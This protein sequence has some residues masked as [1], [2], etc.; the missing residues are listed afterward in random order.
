[1]CCFL[2]SELP[3]AIMIYTLSRQCFCLQLNNR[4]YCRCW[5]G[6]NMFSSAWGL[7]IGYCPDVCVRA[8]VFAALISGWCSS[9][10]VGWTRE[11]VQ[12]L[13][14][15]QPL[16]LSPQTHTHG[17][18]LLP[19]LLKY[20]FPAKQIRMIYC[21]SARQTWP[22]KYSK[23][24]PH[25]RHRA[26]LNRLLPQMALSSMLPLPIHTN[27]HTHHLLNQM[28]GFKWYTFSSPSNWKDLY[29]FYCFS[30]DSFP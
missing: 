3:E 7:W 1:M 22:Y 18:N 13:D 5:V 29:N 11:N 16:L 19:K 28:N 17:R 30:P 10:A 15:K 4:I 6:G 26:L 2:P 27:T 24:W 14:E 12:Q 9:K 25:L 21:L 23:Y 20:S 8:Y